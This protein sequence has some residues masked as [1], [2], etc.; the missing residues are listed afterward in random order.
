MCPVTALCEYCKLRG[1]GEGPL[2]C[3]MD[4]T[5]ISRQ[6]PAK[7]KLIPASYQTPA[8]LLI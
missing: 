8:M 6:M 4:K 3:F 7:G 5:P 2:F 1:P